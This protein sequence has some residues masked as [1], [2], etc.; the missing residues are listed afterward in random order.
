MCVVCVFPPHIQR[1]GHF[2]HRNNHSATETLTFTD[3]ELLAKLWIIEFETSPDYV[4]V[5]CDL[6]CHQDGNGYIDEQELDAL[7]KDLCD[8]NKMVPSLL[9]VLFR[10]LF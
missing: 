5:F 3:T 7:L 9:I 6:L 2:S 8:K 4:H 1:N 10:L